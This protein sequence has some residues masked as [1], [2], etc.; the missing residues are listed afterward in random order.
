M[1]LKRCRVEWLDFDGAN[2]FSGYAKPDISK[3]VWLK[4]FCRLGKLHDD[5]CVRVPCNRTVLLWTCAI[6]QQRS[7]VF[8]RSLILNVDPLR[9]LLSFSFGSCLHWN[10]YLQH[11]LLKNLLFVCMRVRVWIII[12]NVCTCVC[13]YTR[14]NV[15]LRSSSKLLLRKYYSSSAP[16]RT[17]CWELSVVLL[18]LA[19]T[20]ADVQRSVHSRTAYSFKPYFKS[21]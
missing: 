13:N 8:G 6:G 5:F 16:R 10:R 1:A 2:G 15:E 18:C 14:L 12:L 4:R 20:F 7:F 21:F 11:N 3:S 9:A 17:G 19:K